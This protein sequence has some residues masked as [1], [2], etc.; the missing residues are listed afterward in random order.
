MVTKK[1]DTALIVYSAPL[2]KKIRCVA[3]SGKVR[4]ILTPEE[5]KELGEI[6]GIHEAGGW[7]MHKG[8]QLAVA[9]RDNKQVVLFRL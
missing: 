9:V 7:F 5:H 3:K 2:L 4:R 8:S 1:F 6:H